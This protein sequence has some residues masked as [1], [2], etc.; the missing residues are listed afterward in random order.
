MKAIVCAPGRPHGIEFRDVPEPIPDRADAVVAV[1]AFSL[2]RGEVRRLARAEDGWRPG[3]DVAG[4]VLEAAR[5]G[6]GP[7]AG[8]S[9]SLRFLREQCSS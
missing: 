9:C 7:P 6:S 8:T 4:I 3:Y 2:N 1:Q 5:D